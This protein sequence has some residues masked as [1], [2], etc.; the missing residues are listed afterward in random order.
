MTG[1]EGT[2]ACAGKRYLTGTSKKALEEAC[3]EV[4]VP[5]SS[6]L[7]GKMI[8]RTIPSHKEGRF[9]VNPS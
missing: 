3:L 8:F 2:R 4:S 5:L 1:T 6:R 7:S 9:E